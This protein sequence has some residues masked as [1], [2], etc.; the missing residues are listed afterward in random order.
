[1]DRLAITPQ[2]K[3][4]NNN[5]VVVVV[6]MT[7]LT[8]IYPTKDYSAV[9]LATC[10]FQFFCTYG[11]FDEIYM[12]PGSDMK[13]ELL[14]HLHKWL[15]IRQVFS[16]V[17]RHESNGVEGT[18]K[19]IL[20]HLKAL[21][22]DERVVDRWSDPTV[23][24]LIC[25]I[26]NSTVSSET[27]LTPFQ[28]HFGTVQATYL[29]MPK[30]DLSQKE[31]TSE[32]V[33]LLDKNLRTLHEISN[34]Y[35][36]DIVE[37]R[38]AKTPEV[39]QNMYQPGDLILFQLNPEQPLPSK[40]TP[41]FSGPYKVIQQLKNDIEAKHLVQGGIKFLHV[42]RVKIF[43]GTEEEAYEMAKLD[44]DQFLIL[45]IS[46]YR[47]DPD[48]RTSMQ[49]YIRYEDGDEMWV[50]WS[51]E[52]FQTVQYEEFCRKNKPLSP[53]LFDVKDSKKFI[54]DMNKENI[55]EVSPGDTVYV[56][57]RSHGNYAWYNSIGLD[58]S[59]FLTYVVECRYGKYKSITNKKMI[60]INYPLFNEKYCVDR[61]FVLFYGS[62]KIFLEGAMILIDDEMLAKYPMILAK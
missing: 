15:G 7:K 25:H 20:R 32:F 17:D 51:R 56:D 40:L 48:T 19:Q 54:S 46:A 35:Q 61:S 18:N 42:S 50:T 5:L 52:L 57:I 53:L 47:G 26:I 11:I 59:D 31:L 36:S 16:L 27:G 10:L 12:D 41:K 1:V 3:Y 62:E 45:E 4:G 21:V 6:H 8:A 44:M 58:K 23:L 24:P 33:R 55:I 34:K 37:K 39:E 28:A 29:R 43:H 60:W 13:S 22:Y 2:D 30:A 38:T 49:F 9:T 14:H